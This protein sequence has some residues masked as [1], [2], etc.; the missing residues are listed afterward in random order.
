[1]I[2]K[3]RMPRSEFVDIKLRCGVVVRNTEPRLWRWKPWPEGESG[4]DIVEYQPPKDN[5]G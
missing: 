3:G 4:G 2:N 1:M 5:V